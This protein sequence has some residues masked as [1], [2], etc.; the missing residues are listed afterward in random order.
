MSTFN[1][2]HGKGVELCLSWVKARHGELPQHAVHAGGNTYVGRVHHNNEWIPGKVVEG[3]ESAYVAYD[4]KEHSG[5]DY[6]ILVE[7]GIGHES[8]KGYKWKSA[9]N[10]TVPKNALIAGTDNGKLLYVAR[11][12]MNGEMCVGKLFPEHGGAYMP[13]GGKENKVSDYEVLCFS[14]RNA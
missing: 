1:T 10:G 6:E 8:G 12:E 2:S 7:C 11:A 4:G 13:W 5:S 3:H 14:T 9:G